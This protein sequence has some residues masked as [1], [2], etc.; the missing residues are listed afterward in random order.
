MMTDRLRFVLLAATAA[1]LL[2]GAA[3]VARNAPAALRSLDAFHVDR[4]EVLGTHY[5]APDDVLEAS[6]IHEG[7]SVFDDVDVWHA[8]LLEHPLID[9]VEIERDLPGTIVLRIDE[10]DPIAFA[11][12]PVLRPVDV[13]GRVLP[14]DLAAASLDLPILSVP[15][16]V[17][18]GGRLTNDDARALLAGL[19]RLNRLAPALAQRISELRPTP[20]GDFGLLLRDPAGAQ[21]LLPPDAGSARFDQL[22]RTLA[23]LMGRG[24]L[25]SV[26]RIDLRF[27]DQIVV[28]LS[29][30]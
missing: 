8:A 26:R 7:S 25:G 9:A 18:P 4:V 22:R 21:L 16:G 15:A 28:A 3:L 2:G 24:E 17:G 30:G 19:Q 23:D 29:S 13:A 11:R 6:R 27:R 5:L 12:T 20:S 10:A 14:I 1:V